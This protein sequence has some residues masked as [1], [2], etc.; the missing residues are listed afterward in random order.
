MSFTRV[1]TCDIFLSLLLCSAIGHCI[2]NGLIM[3]DEEL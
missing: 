1:T 3:V 2:P